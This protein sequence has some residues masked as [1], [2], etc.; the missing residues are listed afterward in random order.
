MF[1]FEK[2][3][4]PILG[5]RGLEADLTEEEQAIQEVAHRFAEEVMRPIGEQ[6]DR[7]TPAEVIADDSPL[8]EYMT[9]VHES[10]ILDYAPSDRAPSMIA[11]SIHAHSAMT[12]QTMQ[13]ANLATSVKR[14][15]VSSLSVED[16]KVWIR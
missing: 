10:G 4:T 11:C 5:I 7:M 3:E 15:T 1:T 16:F 2:L 14:D 13:A 6:L 8:H 12:L 9:K